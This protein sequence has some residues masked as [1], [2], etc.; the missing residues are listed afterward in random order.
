MSAKKPLLND[1][2]KIRPFRTGEFIAIANGGTGADDAAGARA[3]LGL[4]LGTD[5]QAYDA[6][7]AAIAA[8]SGTNTIYYRSAANTW[9]GVTIGATLSFSAGTLGF[10]L[11]HAN[12]WTGKQDLSGGGDL[13]PAAAPSTTA[14]GYLGAPQN[15]GLDSGT[16]NLALT[17]CGKSIDHTDS[18]AR[19]LVIPANGSVAFP[20]GTVIVGSNEGSGVVTI[21]ITTDTLRWGSSTGSRA[22]AQ[23]GSWALR[24]VTSTVWRLT[25]DGIS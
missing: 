15:L 2:A 19:S 18:N 23:H 1:A 24:K 14:I 6:D 16:V 12:T 22:I 25:G 5:V 7:L 20:I 8:L 17:D 4:A 9:S 13:T 11:A 10:D 3:A 21:S